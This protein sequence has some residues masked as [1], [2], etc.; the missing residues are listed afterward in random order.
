MV[1]IAA[2]GFFGNLPDIVRYHDWPPSEMRELFSTVALFAVCGAIF[3]TVAYCVFQNRKWGSEVAL[4]VSTLGVCVLLA[5]GARE[6]Y[7]L[8]GG[9]LLLAF[10][11]TPLVF[12]SVWAFIDLMRQRKLR[13]SETRGG[14]L[15]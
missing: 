3:L 14:Q 13:T 2:G 10:Y 6:G 15:A 5:A 11:G 7:D 4:A 9:I 12:T 1:L 8:A